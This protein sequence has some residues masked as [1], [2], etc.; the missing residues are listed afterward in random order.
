MTYFLESVL[1]GKK[2]DSLSFSFGNIL[3]R[4][5]K[6]KVLTANCVSRLFF[7]VSDQAVLA[8]LWTLA[9]RN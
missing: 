7:S 4:A 9:Q 5:Q 8:E 1:Q 6:P 3:W 2:F